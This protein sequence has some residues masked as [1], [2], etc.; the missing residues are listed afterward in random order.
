[1]KHDIDY[2]RTILSY[3]PNTGS[4]KWLRR[5]VKNK[6]D[7]AFNTRSTTKTEMD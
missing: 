4:F 5:E 7:K 2:L 6:Y 3:N 1:M